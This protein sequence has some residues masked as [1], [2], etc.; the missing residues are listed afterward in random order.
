MFLVCATSSL[1][2]YVLAKRFYGQHS[3][4]Q[5][6]STAM[7]LQN[8]L[9]LCHWCV[10]WESMTLFR[11]YLA[12]NRMAIRGLPYETQFS[13]NIPTG[14]R[15]AKI[16]SYLLGVAFP[17]WSQD[18]QL[19]AIFTFINTWNDYF[20]QLVMLTSRQKLDHLTQ[21]AAM[22]AEMTLTTVW[23]WQVLPLQLLPIVTVF[24]VFQKILHSRLL[25]ELSK[26][27]VLCENWISLQNVYQYAAV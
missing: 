14:S 26:R 24:L 15:S 7:A 20:M 10:S 23:S 13:E 8:K 5:S 27:I 18:L 12:F 9:S 11:R 19:F 1:A 4:Y 3:L 16:D 2:G 22:Q 6:L 21:V 25:W 17:V